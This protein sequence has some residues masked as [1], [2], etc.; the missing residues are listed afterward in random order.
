MATDDKDVKKDSTDLSTTH[1]VT[2]K[3]SMSTNENQ[4]LIDKA[5]QA[6]GS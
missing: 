3:D 4:S 2:D 6:N 1:Y 5:R